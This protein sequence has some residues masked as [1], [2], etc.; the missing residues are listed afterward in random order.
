[1]SRASVRIDSLRLRGAHVRHPHATAEDFAYRV[2]ERL[3]QAGVEARIG[4]VRVSCA[5]PGAA[6]ADRV[7]ARILDAI[8]ARGGSWR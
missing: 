2:A 3:A 5:H 4:R 1:M 7:A 8:R 6:S